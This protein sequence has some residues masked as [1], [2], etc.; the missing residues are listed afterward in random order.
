MLV[1]L[2]VDGVRRAAKKPV[3]VSATAMRTTRV[4]E[5]SYAPNGS[6]RCCRMSND[7]RLRI[8]LDVEKVPGDAL[9]VQPATMMG[10]SRQSS[11]RCRT[12]TLFRTRCVC[13]QY[14]LRPRPNL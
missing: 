11:V 1:I 8:Y 12:A 7:S 2:I 13:G 5:A 4:P 14:R 10:L 9:M 6:C 3:D